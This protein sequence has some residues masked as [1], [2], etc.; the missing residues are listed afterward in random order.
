MPAIPLFEGTRPYQQIPFQFSV[1]IQESPEAKL[2]HHEFLHKERSDPRHP[3]IE[4]LITFCGQEGSV[5]VYNQAFEIARNN[6]LAKD[7]PRYAF[8]IN[9]ITERM[10]DLLVP[11][12]NRW[13]YHP[14]Q[15]SSASI[16]AVLPCFTNLSYEGMEIGHGGEAMLQYGAFLEGN[17]KPDDLPFLWDNL[18]KYCGQDTYAMKLLLD[19]LREMTLTF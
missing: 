9:S 3:F 13:L 7:F 8:E 6:E 2:L 1:H 12:K 5:I 18:I 14:D 15:K 10:V 4:N 19:Q 11:F 16:K 17:L